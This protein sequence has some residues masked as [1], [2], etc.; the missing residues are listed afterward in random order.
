LKDAA[1]VTENIAVEG[2]AAAPNCSNVM[3]MNQPEVAV[4]TDQRCNALL[5]RG[6]Y[7]NAARMGNEAIC[8]ALNYTYE[9]TQVTSCADGNA[10]SAFPLSFTTGNA[11][12]Y[13]RLNVLPA[14]GNNGAWNVRIRPN[15]SY[16]NGEFG[17]IQRIQVSG[18]AASVELADEQA[19]EE[20]TMVISDFDMSVFPNPGNG[21]RIYM[22]STDWEKGIVDVRLFDAAGR[23]ITN[24]SWSVETGMQISWV[25]DRPLNAGV[26]VVETMQSGRVHTERLVVE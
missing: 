7:L 5:T 11:S 14:L 17:S 19:T 12:P 1:G 15:F 20:R 25:F 16:G 21:D 4:R 2:S 18:T 22:R 23:L 9:F 6:S 26:Y 13:L 10:V 3:I 24:R 8:G